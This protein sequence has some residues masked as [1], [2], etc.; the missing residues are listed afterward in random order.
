[1]KYLTEGDVLMMHALILD[2]T[3]GSH[4]VRDTGLLKS[5]IAR[6]K[7]AFGGKDVH[8]DLWQKAAI[9]FESIATYHVFIDGN[10]RTSVTA[11]ARFL[12]INGYELEAANEEVVLFTLRVA[13]E[14][15]DIKIIADWLQKH[16][17][18]KKISL[19]S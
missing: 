4:G 16:S 13:T 17:A 8:T 7:Q 6:P 9:Y 14:K 19:D 18:P 15:L 1:M 3:T 11:T 12:S 2:E 5:L 10:K